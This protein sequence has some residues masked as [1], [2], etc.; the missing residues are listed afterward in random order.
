MIPKASIL[1]TSGIQNPEKD[2][3]EE[4]LSHIQELVL[5]L[6]EAAGEQHPHLGFSGYAATW[7]GVH[8]V[9]RFSG[10]VSVYT[11][12]EMKHYYDTSGV[13]AYLCQL[14][15]PVMVE[16]NKNLNKQLTDWIAFTFTPPTNPWEPQF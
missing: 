1:I 12:Q 10:Y 5:K 16:H 7:D 13:V 2:L 6:N 8:V 14:L 4:E 15:T 11:D 9:A 3:T